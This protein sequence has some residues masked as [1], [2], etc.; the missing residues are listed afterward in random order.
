[1]PENGCTVI[2][3]DKSKPKIGNVS[4]LLRDY[5]SLVKVVGN[6]PDAEC[7]CAHLLPGLV[8]FTDTVHVASE[9]LIGLRRWMPETFFLALYDELMPQAET[10]F[11]CSG[12]LFLGSY[13][14]F[15]AFSRTILKRMVNRQGGTP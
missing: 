5:F 15:F 4:A 6:V 3:G 2:L 9:T 11:R 12:I 14:T 7:C 10:L 8:V 13:D 1:M